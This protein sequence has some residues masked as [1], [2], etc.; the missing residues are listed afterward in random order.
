MGHI[1]QSRKCGFMWMQVD[2]WGAFDVFRVRAL[3]GGRPL[4]RVVL[5]V[6]QRFDLIEKLKLPEAKLRSFLKVQKASLALSGT[7]RPFACSR[8]PA[9]GHCNACITQAVL[10]HEWSDGTLTWTARLLGV[11]SP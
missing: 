10:R 5:A 8:L 7:G 11:R 1:S 6:L 3:S 4:Q 9:C 2:D